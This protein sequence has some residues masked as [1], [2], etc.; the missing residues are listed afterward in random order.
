MLTVFTKLNDML[1][2]EELKIIF[3]ESEEEMRTAY[4][5]MLT[6]TKQ[7]GVDKLEEWMNQVHSERAA[8][9]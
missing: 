6:K 2:T 5:T 8:N 3:A 9:K 7:I 1:K 4:D